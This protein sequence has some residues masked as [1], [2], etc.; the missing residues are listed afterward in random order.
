ML[1]LPISKRT[2]GRALAEQ[3]SIQGARPM[4][5]YEDERYTY[6]D[7]LKLTR[8]YAGALRTAGVVHG[9]HVALLMNNHPNML[10]TMF[11]LA[12]LGGVAV[13]I[14]TAAKG[15]LLQYF[16]NHSKSDTLIVDAAMLPV[17]VSALELT[18]NVRRVIVNQAETDIDLLNSSADGR[19]WLSL[20]KLVESV[21][22]PLPEEEAVFTDTQIVMYTSGTTG[23][24]KGVICTQAMEQTGG[25]FMA[26]QMSYVPEDV[27]YTCLPLFHANA[28]RVTVTAA[29]WSGAAVALSRRFSAT[30]FW[31]E[32]RKFGA[33]QFNSLG[34]MANILIQ[35]PPTERDHDHRVR[36]C[37][38]VPAL[39][40]S[41]LQAFEE[42]FG[43]RVTSLYGSTE[44]C[45]P[46][47]ATI[48]TPAERWPT[49]GRIIPPFEMKVVDDDD[50]ELPSGSVGE[51]VIRCAEPWHYFPGYLDMPAETLAAWRNGWFHSGDRGYIDKE[52]Y[53][54]VVDRKKE[55]VRRRGENISSYEVEMLICT[56]PSVLETAVVPVPAELGE[57]DVLAFVVLRDESSLSE[58]ELIH[59]CEEKMAAFMVPRFV[60]F[61]DRLP[62]TPSEKVEKYLLKKQAELERSSLWDREQVMGRLRNQSARH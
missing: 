57:D 23:P 36:I 43:L 19:E 4:L 21:S 60:R 48:D 35:G 11:A 46:V 8:S 10:W 56:H 39:P 5:M 40:T 55:T 44:M 34:A 59:F 24:S 61:I 54:Y 52:G 16:L 9:A 45:C 22:T 13:P 3:A 47:Y 20:S 6:S 38:I 25:I 31:T 17:V 28:I 53:C 50:F 30:N 32:V 27:L 1:D 42:R 7:A 12:W 58:T 62:K 37:N 15:D 2:L 33:T 41:Q 49:C 14:N 29:L 26:K 51:W 18:P